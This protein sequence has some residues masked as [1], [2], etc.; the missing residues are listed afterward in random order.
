MGCAGLDVSPALLVLGGRTFRISPLRV[1]HLAALE[2]T[3]IESRED[4]WRDLPARLACLDPAQQQALLAHAYDEA[5]R[6]QRA[7][8]LE[9][10]EY[11]HTREGFLQAL[12]L[13]ARENESELRYEDFVALVDEMPAAEWT[14]KIDAALAAMRLAAGNRCGQAEP[15]PAS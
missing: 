10:D 5:S 12:W 2:R 3:L 14:E 4:P 11:F 7:T 8:H 15:Q 6:R 1:R 9:V 13:C